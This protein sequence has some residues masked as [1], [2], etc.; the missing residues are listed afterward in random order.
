[1]IQIYLNNVKSY[2][3][4]SIL[5]IGLPPRT[6][7]CT[8]FSELLGFYFIFFLYFFSFLGRELD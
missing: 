2:P 1:M 4:L 3:V 6:F 5:P 7:A 8:V